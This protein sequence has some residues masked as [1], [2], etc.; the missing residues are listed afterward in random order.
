MLK[1]IRLAIGDL[2]AQVRLFFA[3]AQHYS[4]KRIVTESREE[5]DRSLEVF[6]HARQQL[7]AARTDAEL[8]EMQ[9]RRQRQR[10]AVGLR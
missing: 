7:L 3:E 5:L 1:K 8:A 6:K 2:R 4:A 10:A 9:V